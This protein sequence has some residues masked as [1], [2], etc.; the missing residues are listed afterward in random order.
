MNVFIV[1]AHHEPRSFNA[2]L[3][4]RAR[5]V[6]GGLG[7]DVVVSDLYAMS[8]DPVSD[9]RNFTTTKNPEF[10]KQQAEEGYASE[11]DGFAADI[12]GEMEKLERC[13][14]VIFQFPLWWFGLPGILKG[15]VDRVFAAG[16]IYGGGK[17]YEKGAFAGKRAL[18]SMT[19]G[20]PEAMFDGW[21]L[22]PSL[23]SVL[24][25]IQH[26]IFW[27]TGFEPLPP[28]IAWAVSRASE[29][30]R[31]E[32]LDAYAERMRRLFTDPVIRYVRVSDCDPDMHD[33]V[34]RFM[35]SWSW[36]GPDSPEVDAL[37]PRE[38][39]ILEQWRREGA[40]LERW[41][42]GDES[43]GWLIVREASLAALHARLDTL[44]LR[45]WLVVEVTPL[46][47]H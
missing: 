15:W 17:W 38:R 1:H 36:N 23:E 32:Y 19:T 20:G 5:D 8:F 4:Q 39:A 14:A 31:A 18:V 30:R 44:P 22:N 13:D 34:P 24:G 45:A 29:P 42:A 12:R 33:R 25:P 16:R 41:I 7:H 21:G 26:G 47:H 37:V 2:A 27:F 35:V 9:R 46:G 11:R 6:L 43:R 40:L 28:F 10:L 3:T